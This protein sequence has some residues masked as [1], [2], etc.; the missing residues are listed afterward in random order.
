MGIRIGVCGTGSFARAF[1]PL[2]QAHPAVDEVV[3]A[4]LLPDRLAEQAAHFGVART[5]DSLDALCDSDVDAIALFTQRHLHGPQTLQALA[6]GKHVYCAVPIANTEA[7]I[8]AIVQAVADTRLIYMTGETSYYYPA[9]L[10]CRSRFRAGDFGR[11]VYGEGQY[12]HDMAHGFYEA[13]QHSGGAEWKRVAGIPPMHYPT[14]SV[15]MI[16]SV[17]G[18]HVTHVSCL[19]FDD[20]HEDGV[21]RPGANLW[22]NPYSNQT[23]LMRTSDG[24]M[25]RINEFRRVGWKGLAS[26]Q[27]SLFG[28]QGCYQEQANAQAWVTLADGPE[29]VTALLET[30]NLPVEKTAGVHEAVLQDY[31]MSVSQVHSVERLPREFAG[32]RNGH[33]GSHQFLADDF[34]KAVVTG[35]LPPNHVWAAARYCLP[36]LIA[37]QSS[38]QEGAMLPLPDLGDPPADWPL[39]DLDTK[40]Q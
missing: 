40:L 4:D 35:S 37:H 26:V 21:F 5:V 19:G 22:D 17:T 12:Y 39:L 27:M 23:A 34:V 15:S 13:Y 11:F 38:L 28:T 6:A 29:D 8:R 14:H 9:T 2:F 10:Y 32:L 1:I 18:A 7:E 16:L 30:R 31:H 36:G 24:G 25:M 20:Q 3:L 33:H